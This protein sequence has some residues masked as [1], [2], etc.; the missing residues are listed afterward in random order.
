[1]HVGKL[2]ARLNP[3]NVRFDVGAGG[4]P[5]LTST[6]IAAAL[7][8]VPAGLGRELLCL[9]WWPDSACYSRPK[10]TAMVNDLMMAE[11]SRRESAMLDAMLAV[12]VSTG[13][14]SLSRARRMYDE[15]HAA[16]W[17]TMTHVE[18]GITYPVEPYTRMAMAVIAEVV[19]PRICPHCNGSCEVSSRAGPV[20]CDR[21]EGRG[22]V[23]FS[24]TGRAEA[25]RISESNYRNNWDG[26]Y[27]WL[28]THC[29]EAV[30]GAARAME[31]AAA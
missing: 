9:M 16:R 8:M 14:T 30:V 12:S 26:V 21:C 23:P 13:G 6:D 15:A 31:S 27:G 7:G 1:M 10:A 2:M 25:L 28:V 17:P 5:E 18:R 19:T 24:N 3:K 20:A 11:W 22:T 29:T 4:I